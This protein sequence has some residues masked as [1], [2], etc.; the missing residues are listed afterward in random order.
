MFKNYTVTDVA[1]QYPLNNIGTAP[2]FCLGNIH[3]YYF[4]YDT[5]NSEYSYKNGELYPKCRLYE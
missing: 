1:W 4:D 3:K 2:Y 5:N